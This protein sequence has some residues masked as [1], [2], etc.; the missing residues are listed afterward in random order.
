VN[1]LNQ[2]VI[3]LDEQLAKL[4]GTVSSLSFDSSQLKQEQSDLR[5][6]TTTWEQK[7]C[8]SFG[9]LVSGFTT[10]IGGTVNA[11]YVFCP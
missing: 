4:N 3:G 7:V 1:T 8:P 6:A 9:R 10:S 11:V 5:T 2:N